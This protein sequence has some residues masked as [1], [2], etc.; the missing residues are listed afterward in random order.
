[1]FERLINNNLA[2][3]QLER[4]FRMRDEIAE[5]LRQLKIYKDLKTDSEVNITN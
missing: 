2:H 5:L 1:M 4:Q 3:Q